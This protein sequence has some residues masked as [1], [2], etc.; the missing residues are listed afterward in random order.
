[1]QSTARSGIL[2]VPCT[3]AK[4]GLI[5]SAWLGREWKRVKQP[6]LNHLASL[7]SAYLEPLKLWVHCAAFDKTD[8]LYLRDQEEKSRHTE[9]ELHDREVMSY[10]EMRAKAEREKRAAVGPIRP[11]ARRDA[12]TRYASPQSPEIMEG[13]QPW[14]C[15]RAGL[16]KDS[17]VRALQ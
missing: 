17:F 14:C 10:A 9:M 3:T 16:D 11:A 4:T 13:I 2:R 12:K 7:S 1:M 6:P 8:L 5:R 15:S